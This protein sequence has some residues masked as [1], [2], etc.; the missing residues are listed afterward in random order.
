MTVIHINTKLK[1]TERERGYPVVVCLI[2][3]VWIA[4]I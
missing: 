4:G 1:K 2:Y 3:H